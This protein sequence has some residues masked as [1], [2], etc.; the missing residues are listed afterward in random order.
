MTGN[1]PLREVGFYKT[2]AEILDATRPA[3]SPW[4]SSAAKYL[5][6][7][8]TILASP[9]WVNDMLDPGEKK[10]C[11]YATLTDGLWVWP[12]SLSYYLRKY[13]IALP[14]DFLTHMASRN[15]AVPRIDDSELDSICEQLQC[16]HDIQ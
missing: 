3:E 16:Q 9:V 5:E 2:A 14:E 10:I 7:G 11:Q 1:A 12:K 13:H 15:W 4:G 6:Q 8:V